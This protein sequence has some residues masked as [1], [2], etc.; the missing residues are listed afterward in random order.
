MYLLLG[1]EPSSCQH[2]KI[3]HFQPFYNYSGVFYTKCLVNEEILSK[4]VYLSVHSQCDTGIIN[5]TP[6][7]AIC[8]PLKGFYMF[9]LFIFHNNWLIHGGFFFYSHLYP[10]TVKIKI[11]NTVFFWCLTFHSLGLSVG[12]TTTHASTCNT[13]IDSSN[14]SRFLFT[15]TGIICIWFSND[16]LWWQDAITMILMESAFIL[17]QDSRLDNHASIILW[18]HFSVH[19]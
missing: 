14:V 10:I 8:N 6:K 11:F 3:L 4:G 5:T 18:W 16:L 2:L 12:L 17:I 1:Q 9:V 7:I 19:S 15:Y 13:V